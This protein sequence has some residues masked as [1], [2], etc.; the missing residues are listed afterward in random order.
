[1]AINIRRA[2]LENVFIVSFV[3][4]IVGNVLVALMM[5]VAIT[6]Y[7]FFSWGFSLAVIEEVYINKVII[8]EE[9]VRMRTKESQLLKI[10][11]YSIRE[12]PRDSTRTIIDINRGLFVVMVFAVNR[13]IRILIFHNSFDLQNQCS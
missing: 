9:K 3:S 5:A 10:L 6:R 8:P 7:D 12:T 11:L 4:F 1:M 2:L 13:V